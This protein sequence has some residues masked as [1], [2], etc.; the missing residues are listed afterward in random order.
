MVKLFAT[1]I[2]SLLAFSACCQKVKPSVEIEKLTYLSRYC[3]NNILKI[4]GVYLGHISE[5]IQNKSIPYIFFFQNGF[6]FYGRNKHYNNQLDYKILECNIDESLRNIPYHWGCYCVDGDTLKL[7]LVDSFW[8]N[9]HKYEI[10]ERWAKIVNDSTI[11]F[12]KSFSPSKKTSNLNE[13]YFFKKCE[14]KPDSTN[15]LMQYF[16]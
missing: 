4:N 8:Q 16:E 15:I 3:T 12:F 9:K 14:V 11:L 10:S 2:M 6:V 7:Q 13:L 1:F 5:L